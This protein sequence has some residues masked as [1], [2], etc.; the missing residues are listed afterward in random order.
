MSPHRGAGCHQDA[1]PICRGVCWP[2]CSTSARY[3]WG[4]S[5][6]LRAGR[7]QGKAGSGSWTLIT[8]AASKDRVTPGGIPTEVPTAAAPLVCHCLL[9]HFLALLLPPLQRQ[10]PFSHWAAS[11][12]SM[13]LALN[14]WFQPAEAKGHRALAEIPSG[15]WTGT[16]SPGKAK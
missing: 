10:A 2:S 4:I 11:C 6:A 14:T 1:S 9:M 12:L 7:R 16:Y 15:R 8:G 5:L 13:C 3:S